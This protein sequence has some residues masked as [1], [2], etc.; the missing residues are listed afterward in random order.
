MEKQ[1]GLI[2][3]IIL[4]IRTIELLNKLDHL[5]DDIER[6]VSTLDNLFSMIDKTTDAVA[7]MSDKIVNTI[8][9]YIMGLIKRKDRDENE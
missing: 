2:V 7:I 8:S 4:G 5:T 1:K 3:L 6:K 9:G